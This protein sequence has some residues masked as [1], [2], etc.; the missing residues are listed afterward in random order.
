MIHLYSYFCKI[1]DDI[2]III[3]LY[4]YYIFI[5]HENEKYH[6]HVYIEDITQQCEDVIFIFEW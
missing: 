6:M 4:S 1:K 3:H 2:I 5:H